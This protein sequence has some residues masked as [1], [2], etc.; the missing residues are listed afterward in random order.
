[1][2]D[3]EFRN[4]LGKYRVVRPENF[5]RVI[6]KKA[7]QAEQSNAVSVR[8]QRTSSKSPQAARNFDAVLGAQDF[9]VALDAYLQASGC[10]V[11]EAK[12][13]KE[14]FKQAHQESF[15]ALCFDD[16]EDIAKLL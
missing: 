15:N 6:E 12:K 16:F 4:K 1:M 5:Y 13:F 8:S 7:S 9:W 11:P 3:A 10:S 14:A 2:D